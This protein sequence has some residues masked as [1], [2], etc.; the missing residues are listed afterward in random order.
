VKSLIT[1][2]LGLLMVVQAGVQ[3]MNSATSAKAG[4]RERVSYHLLPWKI[5]AAL[6]VL[7]ILFFIL[8]QVVWGQKN[9]QHVKDLGYW[10]LP[11]CLPMIA[12]AVASRRRRS[13]QRAQP[14]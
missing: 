3:L 9:P 2:A 12:F 14:K 7:P 11:F 4:D 10:V 5:Y 8:T 6:S 1:L 13:K